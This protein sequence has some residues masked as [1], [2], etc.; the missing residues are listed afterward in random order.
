MFLPLNVVEAFGVGSDALV[1][2]L[3]LLAE[4]DEVEVRYGCHPEG[5]TVDQLREFFGCVV[6]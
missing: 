5:L 2:A 1:A 3:M 4:E 6:H